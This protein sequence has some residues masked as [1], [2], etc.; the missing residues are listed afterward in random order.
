MNNEAIPTREELCA[1]LASLCHGRTNTYNFLARLYLKEVD[2]QLL[3]DLK[4]MRFPAHTGNEHMD[5]GYRLIA[6][7]LANVWESSLQELAVDYARTF[8][9]SGIDSFSA[10]YPFE[11]VYTSEKRL[12]M[13]SSRDEVLAIYRAYGL[14][15]KANWKEGEDHIACELEFLGALSAKAATSFEEG[16]YETGLGYLIAQK[17][18]LDDHLLLWVPML[19][20]GI[21]KFSKTDFYRGL[22]SLTKGFLEIDRDFL[23]DAVTQ[24]N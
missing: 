21:T 24:G 23:D 7:Y 4:T 14:E 12:T 20:F 18:F 16:S 10:A 6:S 2:E 17:N 19:V 3:A 1:E 11:S 15:K 13:Q 9:G 8:L 22:A 5:H